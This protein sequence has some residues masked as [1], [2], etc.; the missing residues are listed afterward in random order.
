MYS[1]RKGGYCGGG[2]AIQFG[3]GGEEGQGRRE[4]GGLKKIFLFKGHGWV[5]N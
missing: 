3:E 1:R 4:N 2:G 5:E